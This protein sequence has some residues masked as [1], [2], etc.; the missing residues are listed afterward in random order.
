MNNI[1]NIKSFEDYKDKIK[2][3][4]LHGRRINET[5]EL[6]PCVVEI[7][8][9]CIKDLVK[10]SLGYDDFSYYLLF[11]D[12]FSCVKE[13]EIIYINDDVFYNGEDYSGVTKSF[14]NYLSDK[15]NKTRTRRQFNY[16]FNE[17]L[18]VHGVQFFEDKKFLIINF[19]SCDYIKKF[20]LDVLLFYTLCVN[21][22]IK[23]DTF[24]C[25]FGS[26]HIYKKEL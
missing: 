25:F 1:L 5:Y 19:R 11:S 9:D 2:I 24:Y 15:E 22:D 20:P 3:F 17:K 18:C 12:M 6:S 16:H 10:K 7:K 4:K 23:V 26:L 14:D 21:Y 13:K 8:T